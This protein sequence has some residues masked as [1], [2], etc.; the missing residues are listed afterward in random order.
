MLEGKRRTLDTESRR[1][2]ATWWSEPFEI[3]EAGTAQLHY[4][5]GVDR[6][7][8]LAKRF[9]QIVRAIEKDQGG[10]E[11]LSEARQQLIRRFAATAVL[12][13]QI[14]AR[15]AGGEEV[16][17][18]EHALLS[19]SLVRL[20]QRIGINRTAKDITPT[21]SQYRAEFEDAEANQEQESEDA[22]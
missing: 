1:Q 20:V 18:Q 5:Q 15:L 11:R 4:L 12:A 3:S 10:S 2:S 9:K 21:L 6:R 19:S 14:E 22:A 16:N 8:R 7:T 17:A 13:E